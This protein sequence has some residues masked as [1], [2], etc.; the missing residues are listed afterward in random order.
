MA[1]EALLMRLLT[2][3]EACERLRIS[4]ATLYNL[5]KKGT[6]PLVKIGGKSLI[7]EAAIDRLIVQGASA[8][9][10]RPAGA[11]E[12]TWAAAWDEIVRLGLVD[13]ASRRAFFAPKFS[14]FKP[15]KARGKPASLIIIEERG[16]R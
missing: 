13:A 7:K 9:T 1:S 8:A 2:I 14:D 5:T 11:E 16:E 4:R 3:R 12:K 15:A 6:L 10:K